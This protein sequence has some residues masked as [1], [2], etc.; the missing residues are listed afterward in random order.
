MSNSSQ[1]PETISA[2]PRKSEATASPFRL[3]AGLLWHDRRTLPLLY[4]ACIAP[5]LIL[6]LS[7][8]GD[9]LTLF[10]FRAVEH[11]IELAV[12]LFISS[13]T[14]WRLGATSAGRAPG[15]ILLFLSVGMLSWLTLLCPSDVVPFEVLW[16]A[17]SPGGIGPALFMALP[18]GFVW[19]LHFFWSFALILT[20]IALTTRINL[21]RY[22]TQLDPWMPIKAV[23]GPT[24]LMYLPTLLVLAPYP[25]GRS[26]EFS[27]L[28]D[29]LSGIQWILCSYLSLSF[30]LIFLPDPFWRE[31]KLDP[32]RSSRFSTL[33]L[34][35]PKWLASALAPKTACQIL[36]MCML[37]WAA[38]LA[39][40]AQL[41]PSPK[42][43][44]TRIW[45]ED[46][47]HLHV[48]LAASDETFKFRGFR[49][50]QFRLTN[51]SGETIH[52]AFPESATVDGRPEDVRV[53][54][55]EESGAISLQLGFMDMT[56]QPWDV[57]PYQLWYGGTKVAVV[58]PEVP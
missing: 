31:L 54:F 15:T 58:R 11:F 13:K 55:P 5:R 53:F 7:N 6:S 39:R 20:P 21:C 24:A 42:L 57:G 17:G 26:L 36:G 25:D 29:S 38:N 35:A 56:G 3:A 37:V 9:G 8:P 41:P 2:A 14:L 44:L 33:E 47:G 28:A 18:S 12:L 16:T 27:L 1:S 46:G 4:L 23:V 51:E 52:S 49:P 40:L 48:E 22:F 34:Q 45:K 43:S 10:M 30:G 32:Y 50:L 19:Y